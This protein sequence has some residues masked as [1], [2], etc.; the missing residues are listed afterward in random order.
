M[1]Q[2]LYFQKC[3]PRLGMTN[4]TH[5]LKSPGE[6]VRPRFWG[7]RSE[8][9]L[10]SSHLNQNGEFAAHRLES[11]EKENNHFPLLEW[12]KIPEKLESRKHLKISFIPTEDDKGTFHRFL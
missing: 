3:L 4:F 10:G 7:N 1:M 2:V 11:S 8:V 9:G 5:S 12:S 6:V